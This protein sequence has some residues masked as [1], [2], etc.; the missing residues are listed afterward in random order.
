[1]SHRKAYSVSSGGKRPRFYVARASVAQPL[2]LTI[3]CE[4]PTQ[5]AAD[6]IATALNAPPPDQHNVPYLV[7]QKA[8]GD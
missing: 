3:V 2:N 4:A 1:M 8:A 6:E 7:G 5:A